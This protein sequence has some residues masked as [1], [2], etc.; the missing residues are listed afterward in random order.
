MISCH[1]LGSLVKHWELLER[2]R[3]TQ[4]HGPSW[5]QYSITFLKWK[6][7]GGL[8]NHVTQSSSGKGDQKASPVHLQCI[9]SVEH[10]W[11]EEKGIHRV[12]ALLNNGQEVKSAWLKVQVYLH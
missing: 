5:P 11:D 8:L 4:L 9:S 7:P 1:T 12:N 6:V 3:V 10:V 2:H